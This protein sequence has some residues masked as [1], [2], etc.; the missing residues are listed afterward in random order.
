M[1]RNLILVKHQYDA[2]NR[3]VASTASA[4]DA[5]L[6]V[7]RKDRLVTEVQ[8]P[9]KRGILRHE[10]QLL[11]QQQRQG[12]T[13]VETALPTTD[14]QGSVLGVQTATQ[15]HPLAY[16]PYGHRPLGNGLLSLLGFNG[17]RPDPVTGW[18]LLGTGYH[19]P[20]NP[21]LMRFNSP[22]SWSPFGEGGVNAYAYGLG[23]P[24]N[25]IDK[26]GHAPT[27]ISTLMN[28]LG[29]KPGNGFKRLS[30]STTRS[31]V[32][33]LARPNSATGLIDLGFEGAEDATGAISTPRAGLG[34]GSLQHQPASKIPKKIRDKQSKLDRAKSKLEKTNTQLSTV[35]NS[36]TY[37]LNAS[38]KP[39]FEV[40]NILDNAETR[41]L[42]RKQH[43]TNKIKRLES[44]LAPYSASTQNSNIRSK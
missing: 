34:D 13:A 5:D 44:E 37:K 6:R 42:A 39:S 41:A 26:S 36:L 20:F 1:P 22:D 43:L 32:T 16:T 17:E 25:Q 27:F 29:I 21:V 33:Q 40:Q 30:T 4:Q 38:Y 14:Q 10:D 35:R 3:L 23:D 12:N 15:L 9:V 18:Y 11:A 7:Y 8:G 2:L 31:S 24:T 28:F 19:R